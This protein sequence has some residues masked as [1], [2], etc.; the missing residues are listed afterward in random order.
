LDLGRNRRASGDRCLLVGTSGAA[1]PTVL[2]Y[3]TV[4]PSVAEPTAIV[5]ELMRAAH[6]HFAREGMPG[7]PEMD[8]H[9]P[10]SWRSDEAAMAAVIWREQ[11]ARSAGLTQ[12]TERLR[13]RW[14]SSSPLPPRGD[15]LT[16]SPDP[17]DGAFLDTF[18]RVAQGSLDA[19]TRR[20]LAAIGVDEQAKGDL[21]FYLALPGRRENWCLAH[22]GDQLV[23][24]IVPSRSAYDASISYL[25]VVPEMRGHGYVDDLLAEMTSIHVAQGAARVTATTDATNHPMAAAF[26]RADYQ[27]GAALLK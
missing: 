12:S 26:A 21:A 22:S 5:S 8:I 9:T 19:E 20:D 11:A 6:E 23:G 13:L 24:L 4:A 10:A 18:A 2:D 16:F 17:D 27:M 15:R 14:E 1:H 7:L 3:V 25:G